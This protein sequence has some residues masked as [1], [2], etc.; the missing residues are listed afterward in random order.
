[1]VLSRRISAFLVLFG[2]WSWLIWP[3]FLHN[4]WRDPR[5]WHHG[6]T[7]FLGVHAVLTA[8]SLGLGTAVGWLGVC[9]LRA[10]SSG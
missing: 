9:G 5:S 1:M 7:A 4:I 6:P 10:A 3:T 2:V 8:V